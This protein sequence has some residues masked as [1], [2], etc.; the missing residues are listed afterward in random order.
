ML[1]WRICEFAELSGIGGTLASGRWSTIGPPIVYS[2]ES[3]ALALLEVLVQAGIGHPPDDYQLLRI[4]CPDSIGRVEY[5]DMAVP[6]LDRSRAWGDAWLAAGETALA[7]VPS[8][9]A[10]HSFNMLINP[11][12]PAAARIRVN[13]ASRW[14]WDKRLFRSG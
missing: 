12:H 10:P 13:A 2:A 14:P 3:S 11:R 1:L 6:K 8:A 9:I 5:P 7:R 4:E